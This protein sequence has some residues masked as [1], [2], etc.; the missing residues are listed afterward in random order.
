MTPLV[1]L[2]HHLGS[3]PYFGRFAAALSARGRE[4]QRQPCPQMAVPLYGNTAPASCRCTDQHQGKLPREDFIIGKSLTRL[5]MGRIAMDG[6]QRLPPRRPAFPRKNAGL[7]P[8]R[9]LD[10]KSTRLNSSH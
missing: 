7:D 4:E 8:F 6:M 10:R 5:G 3:P 1:L 2:F 9:E